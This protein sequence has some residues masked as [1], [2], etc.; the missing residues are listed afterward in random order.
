LSQL[1]EV[2]MAIA[3]AV[4]KVAYQQNLAQRDFPD[5]LFVAISE[6]VYDPAY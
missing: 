5:D 2:S 6:L 3:L 1:R 4:A